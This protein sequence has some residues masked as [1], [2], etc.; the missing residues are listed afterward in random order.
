MAAISVYNVDT[1]RLLMA[2]SAGVS[3]AE[4]T[5]SNGVVTCPSLNLTAEC[6]ST[7][8]DELEQLAMNRQQA[9][10]QAYSLALQTKD[11]V[12]ISVNNAR[13][14]RAEMRASEEEQALL[15]VGSQGSLLF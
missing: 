12:D 6:N 2:A 1:M 13:S 10:D 15:Q 14:I 11:A 8:A 9:A 7:G 3:Y 5:G 4:T